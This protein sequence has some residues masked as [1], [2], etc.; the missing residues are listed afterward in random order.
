ME[1]A[2]GYVKTASKGVVTVVVDKTPVCARCSAGKGCGAGLLSGTP[3]PAELELPV[4]AGSRLRPGDSVQL[5]VSPAWLLKAAFFAYGIPL[6]AAVLAA[7]AVWVSG[8][9]LSDLSA[10]GFTLLGLSAGIVLSRF[11]LGRTGLCDRF[12]P[13]IEERTGV[14]VV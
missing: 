2:K 8:L 11:L 13:H 12:E 9:S 5:S 6:M 1:T 10:A 7:G 14:P 3:G 4:P